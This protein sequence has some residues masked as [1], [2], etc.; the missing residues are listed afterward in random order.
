M[1]IGFSTDPKRRLAELQTGYPD[2][3]HIIAAIPGTMDDE[4]SWHDIFRDC[5][6]TGEWFS[7]TDDSILASAVRDAFTLSMYMPSWGGYAPL[8]NIRKEKTAL[9]DLG[10]Q[11]GS[12][13]ELAK[14]LHDL[15]GSGDL[16]RLVTS[17]VHNNKNIRPH[18]EAMAYGIKAAITQGVAK[19]SYVLACAV[20]GVNE[21]R[22]DEW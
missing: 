4:R 7:A 13:Y 16:K 11:L 6:S 19:P 8:P 18:T 17:L 9:D 21:E 15:Y 12:N 20:R 5:R 2:P 14:Q 3:L 1:K 10:A 22:V